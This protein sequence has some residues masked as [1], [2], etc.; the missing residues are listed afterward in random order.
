MLTNPFT[1]Q[2][3]SV[4]DPTVDIE[5][6]DRLL[7]AAVVSSSFRALLLGNPQ[8]AVETGFAGE[9]FELSNGSLNV[10]KSIRAVSLRDF[11]QQVHDR[12]PGH[13][14]TMM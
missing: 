11:A 12:L 9:C 6:I 2:R 10:L 14:A 13:M 8:A 1:R 5:T 4:V 7:A 3:V